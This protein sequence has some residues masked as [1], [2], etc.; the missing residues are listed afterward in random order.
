MPVTPVNGAEPQAVR[1]SVP[2]PQASA[3]PGTAGRTRN[4]AVLVLASLLLAVAGLAFW[5]LRASAH[6]ASAA[7]VR[8]RSIAVLPLENLSG[9]QSQEYFVDGMTEQLITDLAQVGSLRVISRTSAMRY[10]GTKK[11]LP[12]IAQE[13]NVDAVVEGSVMRSGQRVRIT[14]QLV[15]ASTDHHL[16]AATYDRELGDVLRMQGEVAQAIAEHVRAQLTPR[17]QARFRSAR[18]VNPE[19]Y[20]PYL[21][22]RYYLSNQFTMVQPLR[23]A[24][25]Y[26]EESVQK[27]PNFALAYSGLADAY[28]Y[29]ALF[30]DGNPSPDQAYRLAKDALGKALSLDDSIGEAHDTLGV[31]S[32]RFEWDL[33]NAGREFDDSIALAPSYSCAHEDRTLYLSFLGRR[34][35]ALAEIA[36]IGELDPGP[37]SLGVTSAAYYQL[38]DYQQLIDA[39]RKAVTSY[40]NEW[41][42]HLSL[43]IGYE[44]TGQRADAM[45][46]YEKA[47]QL[48]GGNPDAIAFL[49]HAYAQVGRTAEAEKILADLTQKAKTSY[50]SPY[51]IA[52]IYGGLH[53]NDQAFDYLEKAYRERDLDMSWHIKADVRLDSLRS[54]R[55]FKDLLSRV[56]PTA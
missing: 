19:A 55:R 42:N 25:S 27:D 51:L 14:A 12:E 18:P 9:D 21:R 35:E 56:T 36:K 41:T 44:A 23:M 31:L 40:P 33:K 20:E 11:R 13:L 50:V 26:F 6:H 17:Q 47:V 8:M 37:G 15:Q 46:E 28:V 30:G 10:K 3:T 1:L 7:A 53:K 4:R 29:L 54:D 5:R 52:T 16:W 49:A 34:D 38:R 32:W 22:G 2:N 43:A 48:S 24:E 39:S 45:S